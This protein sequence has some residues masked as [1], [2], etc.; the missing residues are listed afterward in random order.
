MSHS[1]KLKE[2][3]PY[4]KNWEPKHEDELS[5]ASVTL[6]VSRWFAGLASFTL[7]ALSTSPKEEDPPLH[8]N[9]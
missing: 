5:A 9:A 8:S 1:L 7:S 4:F 6:L 3:E 2:N